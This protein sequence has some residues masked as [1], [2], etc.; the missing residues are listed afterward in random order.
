MEVRRW[1]TEGLVDGV[2]IDH[3]DGLSDPA[4]YL[5]WLREL[6]GPQAWI[7]IEKILAA[8][9][10]LEPTLPVA[11]TTGY[12]ALREI[13]GVFI[14]PAGAGPLTDLFGA[15]RRRLRR[16]SGYRP[17]AQ[18][19]GRDRH[20]RAPNWTGCAGPSSRLPAPT[21]PI[22]P[23]AVATLI[24]HIEV[25]RS[26][27]Q[28]LS[29]VLPTAFADAVAERPELAA[30]LA[31]VAAAL[32]VSAE[33]NVRTTAAVRC[34]DREVD[35]GLP[36]LPRRATGLAQRGR[37]RA[38]PVRCQ[39]RRV[40]SA[41]GGAGKLWPHAMI[42][43][44]TH[45]TKRGEDVR[46]RIGVLSQVPSLWAELVGK[47]ELATPPPDAAT[48]LFLLAEHHSACGPWTARSTHRCGSGCTPT[49]RRRS[50]SPRCTP[51]GT[52]RT[53]NSRLRYTRGS[54]PCWT[55]R[56]APR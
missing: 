27:Y 20:A 19:R 39:C 46:A 44:S 11:G 14:D 9:E 30:P 47:W 23:D 48:G 31:I 5:G 4:G 38:P 53:K 32:A 40:P 45:D 52:T 28:A 50:A 3:P 8:D 12:D 33:A 34:G 16:T 41:C 17:P 15:D 49:P 24:S 22:L 54:T 51:P 36:V 43:L 29:A 18:G 26:D 55:A 1:F 37:R 25:Y 56:S 10:A 7:V 42:A 35:G 2:R 13:G 6:A 21:T